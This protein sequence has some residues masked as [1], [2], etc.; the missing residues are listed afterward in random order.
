MTKLHK[1]RKKAFTLIEIITVVFLGTI[2][3]TAAYAV[4]LASYQSYNRNSESAGLTQNARIA[5]ERMSR[6][7]RQTNEIVPSVPPTT[8][9]IFFQDGHYTSKIQYIN[10]YRSGT[11]LYRKTYHYYLAGLADDWVL[12]TT[13]SALKQ[14]DTPQLIAQNIS[15]LEFIGDNPM[16]IKITVSNGTITYKFETQINPRNI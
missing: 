5:L 11:D 15:N 10:Y 1:N 4:Y 16:I 14:E 2:I 6:E 13:P 3:I 8:S 9:Q 7:I 12:H